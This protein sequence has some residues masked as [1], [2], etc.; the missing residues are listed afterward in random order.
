M[1]IFESHLDEDDKWQE[2]ECH[3]FDSIDDLPN[4]QDIDKTKKNLFIIDDS[5]MLNQNAIA[6]YFVYGRPCNINIIYLTQTY[7]QLPLKSIRNNANYLIL[8][9]L[10]QTDIN[11]V[12]RYVTSKDFKS[13]SDFENFCKESWK[14]PYSYIT[15]EIDN[16]D[17]N[18]RYGVGFKKFLDINRMD[19]NSVALNELKKKAVQSEESLRNAYSQQRNM[20]LG[21]TEQA[22]KLFQPITKNLEEVKTE[23]SGVKQEIHDNRGLPNNGTNTF[24]STRTKVEYIDPNIY[25]EPLFGLHQENTFRKDE[26]IFG[27]IFDLDKNVT[28]DTLFNNPKPWPHR[29]YVNLEE[30][31][32]NAYKGEDEY[33]DRDIEVF[34]SDELFEVLTN[35]I[36]VKQGNKRMVKKEV[37]ADYLSLI[38]FCI[39]DE[40]RNLAIRSK[41]QSLEMEDLIDKFSKVHKF[42]DW[43]APKYNIQSR[44]QPA[45]GKKVKGKGQSPTIVEVVPSDFS[46]QMKRMLLFLG[47]SEAGNK[48]GNL[49]EFTSILDT[50]R[51][52]KKLSKKGYQILLQRFHN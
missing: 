26:Y 33:N 17:P 27:V 51:N 7:F 3:T 4:P 6:N 44:W 13:K 8:F 12:H 36:I 18:K 39:G 42:S 40:L 15:I 31:R 43:I 32:I 11:N 45:R 10:K 29:M 35:N 52:N 34:L 25:E 5:M 1:E 50:M 22:S 41:L 19:L 28:P 47:A 30:G 48:E 20:K 23:V 21:F 37:E 24:Y 2:I 16:K 9:P 46:T 49:N 14:E 38:D